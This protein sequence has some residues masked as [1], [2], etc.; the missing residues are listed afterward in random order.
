MSKQKQARFYAKSYI[1]APTEEVKQFLWSKLSPI[2]TAEVAEGKEL[3]KNDEA[4]LTLEDVEEFLSLAGTNRQ[5]LSKMMGVANTTLHTNYFR[6]KVLAGK[7]YVPFPYQRLVRL[8]YF[9]GLLADQPCPALTEI[10]A[11]ISELSLEDMASIYRVPAQ[12]MFDN[13]QRSLVSAIV[14]GIRTSLLPSVAALKEQ[15]SS[16]LVKTTTAARLGGRYQGQARAESVRE[17][18]LNDGNASGQCVINQIFTPHDILDGESANTLFINCQFSGSMLEG[19]FSNC[20]FINCTGNNPELSG[21]FV[22]SEFYNCQFRTVETMAGDFRN[23][24]WGNSFVESASAQKPI[25]LDEADWEGAVLVDSFIDIGRPANGTPELAFWL[26]RL[27]GDIGQVFE[28]SP[29]GTLMGD[30]TGEE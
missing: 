14:D 21:N 18:L 11:F 1:P 22:G 16:L 10:S 30:C 26:E 25:L 3:V 4:G 17:E 28:D 5:C 13:Q 7:L 20:R 24:T 29:A 12:M 8:A 15:Q 19:D 2:L 23:T 27:R 6:S 9:T